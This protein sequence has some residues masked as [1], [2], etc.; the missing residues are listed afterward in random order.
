MYASFPAFFFLLSTG[1]VLLYLNE[2]AGWIYILS[3]PWKEAP[4]DDGRINN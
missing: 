4:W 3:L 1:S 2:N